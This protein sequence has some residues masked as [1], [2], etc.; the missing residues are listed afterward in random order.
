MSPSDPQAEQAETRPLEGVDR[1]I[2]GPPPEQVDAV[3]TSVGC[4]KATMN[5]LGGGVGRG[6]HASRPRKELLRRNGRPVRPGG[7]CAARGEGGYARE[8]TVVSS[9]MA[10]V[11]RGASGSGGVQ[12]AW[13]TNSATVAAM[14]A[15]LA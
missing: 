11:R 2:E 14:R 6:R 10:M 13:E 3:T 1:E 15:S 8:Q 5:R 4:R 12:S 7:D 9:A